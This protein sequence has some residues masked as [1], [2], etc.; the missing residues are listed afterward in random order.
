MDG[1]YNYADALPDAAWACCEPRSTAEF[2]AEFD[3]TEPIPQLLRVRGWSIFSLFEDAMHDDLIG[4]RQDLN[5]S[6]L[7]ELAIENAFGLAPDSGGWIEKLDVQLEVAFRMFE[8]WQCIEGKQCSQ[9]CFR[10][11]NLQMSK[12]S[13]WPCLKAKA[14]NCS[15]VTEWLATLT[16]NFVHDEL[17][18]VRN[19]CTQAF[20]NIWKSIEATKFPNWKLS[21]EQAEELELQRQLALL[22]YHFLSKRHVSLKQYKFRIRPKYHHWDHGLRRSVRS[23]VSMSLFYS[24]APEDFMGLIARMCNKVHSVSMSKRAM[25]RWL[26]FFF[27]TLDDEE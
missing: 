7:F 23:K 1:F 26:L 17:S 24:F 18:S 10:V 3:P 20:N 11:L 19:V 22:S 21:V 5:G 6:V 8:Q 13:D 4:Q 14:K 2:L 25:Q 16:P 15:V 9:P 12:K 27:G